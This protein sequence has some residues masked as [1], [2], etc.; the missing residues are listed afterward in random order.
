[1]KFTTRSLDALKPKNTRYE[2]CGQNG[3]RLR[4][5][6][7]GIKTFA[8]CYNINGK[9][10]RLTL[11]TYPNTPL[12]KANKL[13]MQ[14]MEQVKEE[15]KDPAAMKQKLLD[16]ERASETI[17][18]LIVLYVNGYAKKRKKTWKE[19]ERAL[20][21]EV[22]PA[23]GEMKVKNVERK[24][25]KNLLN[26]I[27]KRAPVQANRTFEI[28]RKM[29][30]YAIEEEIIETS[31][32]Q[33]VRA[34]TVEKSRERILS[35][36]EIKTVWKGFSDISAKEHIKLA[37][38]LLLITGQ[39]R[40]EVATAKW[41]DINFKNKEWFIPETKSGRSQIVP[42]S[43][44]AIRVLKKIHK[45][46]NES[47]WIFPSPVGEKSIN[48]G[49]LTRAIDRNRDIFK[50]DHWTIHDLRRTAASGMGRLGVPRL[51][52]GKVLN[53]ADP[54]ITGVYDRYEYFSE[55]QEALQKWAIALQRI[56]K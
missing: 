36:D 23:W 13:H 40:G 49:A 20:N 27:A 50:I 35:D 16:S 42:L 51:T 6:P 17:Q 47:D 1:M 4:V 53:H 21:K 14:A 41:S 39:R 28:I 18:E 55:K 29:F 46:N 32:C 48:P 26:K 22:L 5:T 15:G 9:R 43:A 38:Q 10:R 8:Y 31:P 54:H 33:S 3:L 12:V 56:I 30:N 45:I 7:S 37:L 52:I 24:D 34:P 2:V 11:G 19:D 25:V 44:F